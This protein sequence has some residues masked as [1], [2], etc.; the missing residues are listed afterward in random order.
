[1]GRRGDSTLRTPAIQCLMGGWCIHLMEGC[2][3]G[4]LVPPSPPTLST[5]E[6]EPVLSPSSPQTCMRRTSHH[7]HTPST[8]QHPHH[9]CPLPHPPSHQYKIMT[10]TLIPAAYARP[11]LTALPPEVCLC[12]LSSSMPSLLAS[13]V[14]QCS[15]YFPIVSLKCPFF[16]HITYCTS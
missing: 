2:M 6:C 15:R 7:P 14:L 1:M 9:T 5:V 12:L 8:L 13:G 10:T 11:P 3:A 16:L 4:C